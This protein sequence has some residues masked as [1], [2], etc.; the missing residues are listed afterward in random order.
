MYLDTIGEQSRVFLYSCGFGFLLGFLFDVFELTGEF[1][2][3]RKSF[4]V[5]RDIVYMVISTF[6]MFIFSL[7]VDNGSFKFYIY[8]AAVLGWFVYYFS[9]GSFTR[10]VRLTLSTFI[11]LIFKKIKKAISRIILKIKEKRVKKSKKS[12]ISSNLLLQDNEMLLYNKKDNENT[13]G[14]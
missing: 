13:K 4:F 8:A 7:S 9:V 6:L 10:S 3:K 11:K 1:L 2:P 12:E 5:V 14:S